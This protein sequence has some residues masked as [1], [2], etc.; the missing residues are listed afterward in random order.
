MANFPT[1]AQLD[2]APTYGSQFSGGPTYAL[3]FNVGGQEYNFVPK[4]IAENGGLST[5]STTYLMP[6]F[7]SVDNLKDF[8]SKAQQIDISTIGLTKYLNG[9]GL[10]DKGYLIPVGATTFDSQVSPVPTDTFGGE[11]NGLRL[12]NGQ[13]SY[14]LSGGHGQRYATTTGEVHDPYVTKG[15]GLLGEMG[16]AILDLGP[17]A[18]ILANIAM[19]GLGTAIALGT[20]VG[21]GGNIE[22]LAKGYLASQI[23]NQIGASVG[24]ET[25]S[26]VA[27]N[28]AGNT[29]GSVIAGNPLDQ[30][31]ANA[32]INAGTSE[33][34][35]AV[36]DNNLQNWSQQNAQ[37]AYENAPSPTEQDV[38]AATNTMP[39]APLSTVT[40]PLAEAQNNANQ[41]MANYNNAQNNITADTG[42]QVATTS[43]ALPTTAGSLAQKEI[44]KV[45]GN[46]SDVTPTAY[47]RMTAQANAY[48]AQGGDPND[49]TGFEN[50]L[51]NQSQDASTSST[52]GLLPTVGNN[53]VDQTGTP[54]KTTESP[55]SLPSSSNEPV[56][57]VVQTPTPTKTP[58]PAAPL[59][60]ATE[61]PIQP[62]PVTET[63]APTAPL[64]VATETPIAPPVVTTESTAPLAQQVQSSQETPAPAAPLSIATENNSPSVVN[65]TQ[66]STDNS[67]VAAPLA[68]VPTTSSTE[69]SSS[70]QPPLTSIENPVVNQDTSTT[71]NNTTSN[72]PVTAND[73]PT[74]DV[75][76]D[77]LV[78][79]I[80][81][82]TVTA[83]RLPNVTSADTPATTSSGTKTSLDQKLDSSPQYLSAGTVA[84]AKRRELEKL[85]QLF[86]SLTPELS[87]I[88][89]QHGLKPSHEA[90]TQEASAPE[91]YS[92]KFMSAGGE[93]TVED[94]MTSSAP[95]TTKSKT[96]YDLK[97]EKYATHLAAAPVL[98]NQALTLS[99]LKHL[100]SGLK[101]RP[102]MNLASGGLPTKYTDAA[103]KGHNPEFVTGVTGYY[104]QGKG[105]GQSDDIPAMLHDG[106]YVADADLVAALG[107]GSS[108]A[109][110]E[111]LEKF[112]RQIPHQ[113]SAEGGTVVP[114]KIADG[115]YVFPASFVTAIG[116]GDNKAGAKLL[117]A[118]R[119]EI[120]A[121][122]RSAPTSKIPPKAKSPLDYLKMVKG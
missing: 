89:A 47:A 59:S 101:S 34:K 107:D 71:V 26:T 45:L 40:S 15:G 61:T 80:P 2:A 32:A 10:S 63:F 8:A 27:G 67:N 105:T 23:G 117:D 79:Q 58:A 77:N 100:F 50:F 16:Q 106:D 90:P 12:I 121:H 87:S 5:G 108:K 30:A 110:A 11:L 99:P 84:M 46:N 103:P 35:Q 69:T 43:G 24:S 64:S 17:I 52:I 42:T 86:D 38:L 76:N 85:R 18:P 111:A 39:P 31:L 4:N 70:T 73:T 14:G 96:N 72:A 104:A 29:A 112:R 19:P 62:P 91:T 75:P 78:Q 97:P 54:T 49:L 9:Q 88:L 83:P 81:T 115:E 56:V 6:Y 36:S 60:V 109:G 7:T 74:S 120:R 119:E 20:A 113:Q 51:A 57:P 98:S 21:K 118:M 41:I 94:M 53:L 95:L 114:A 102:T 44:E 33:V 25:G 68:S 1:L 37:N 65:T 122:K 22:D 66:T 13:V 28:I 3:T 82:V 116:K 92:P 55:L 93:M 48:I